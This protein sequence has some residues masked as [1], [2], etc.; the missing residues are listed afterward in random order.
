M[1]VLAQAVNNFP[2]ILVGGV[3]VIFACA[4]GALAMILDYDVRRVVPRREGKIA[5]LEREKD[6]AA[7][8]GWPWQ[9]WLALRIMFIIIGFLIGVFTHIWLLLVVGPIAG[10][11]GF[12]FA[13]SGRA[14]T[15]RLKM[16]RAFLGQ[17]RNLRDRMSVSNQSLDTA[18]QEVGRNSGAELEYV[19]EPL[20]RG[21]SVVGNI[22]EM[23]QRSRS[24][25]VEYASGVLIWARSRSL[26]SLIEAIDEILLP[27]GEAQLA[28]QEESMVTLTQQRAVTFAMSAL[29]IFMFVI[30]IR[31][32][33][34]RTYYESVG[35]QIVLGIVMIIFAIL[36]GAL[37]LLV[38]IGNW[39]RWDLRA[40]AAQQEKL[41]A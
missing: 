16:E 25:I 8:L 39:T 3:L 6:I 35:G 38:R 29:M 24:P 23:G 26:D 4:C 36:V 20:R 32:D 14:A 1:T 13:L 33:V 21:G 9:R 5:L 28:V 34:F 40:L 30:V 37:G 11:V 12:R 27:V 7:G 22:V 31:V 19:F 2:V 17:L 41:G 10:A 18:L 15:R